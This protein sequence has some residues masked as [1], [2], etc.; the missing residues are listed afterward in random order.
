LG[1][2]LVALKNDQVAIESFREALSLG[3]TDPDLYLRLSQLLAKEGPEKL[4]E[5]RSK[6]KRALTLSLEKLKESQKEVEQRISQNSLA[7]QLKNQ[8]Q[9]KELEQLNELAE[10]A[11]THYTR[12]NLSN[13]VQM[14]F[15]KIESTYPGSGQL[16]YLIGE[17]YQ[18]R[19]QFKKAKSYFQEAIQY[20]PRLRE[21]HLALAKLLENSGQLSPAIT[22]YERALSLNPDQPEPY[23]ALIRLYRK[24]GRLNVLCD[25]W[26]A[27][28]RADID[29][30]ILKEF[31]IEALHKSERYEEAKQII[32][33]G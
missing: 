22:S 7:N 23:D 20:T 29:N 26:K 17:Y 21:A 15:D 18:K 13:E 2:V 4:E 3:N 32:K 11:F 33:E 16:L 28:Y 6:S 27:R 14:M 1:I 12:I 10:D 24:Q 30:K 25:R 8:E 19:Q 9:F 5:A 31:L